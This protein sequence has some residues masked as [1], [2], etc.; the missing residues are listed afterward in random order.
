M[1]R[2]TIVIFVEETSTKRGTYKITIYGRNNQV[3]DPRE[4]NPLLLS[5]DQFLL[6]LLTFD[7]A[8]WAWEE[9]LRGEISSF[10]CSEE[11]CLRRLL[12]LQ[13][14]QSSVVFQI[15]WSACKQKSEKIM[16]VEKGNGII[17]ILW[18][19]HGLVRRPTR[20]TYLS[21]WEAASR[22]VLTTTLPSSLH[23]PASLL[24]RT[25]NLLIFKVTTS[26]TLVSEITSTKML[27]HL[28]KWSEVN[29]N[30]NNNK[31]VRS[32][33]VS[34]K[35]GNRRRSAG[36]QIPQETRW[37]WIYCW[38]D[39]DDDDDGLPAYSHHDKIPPWWE[40]VSNDKGGN[41]S[42]SNSHYSW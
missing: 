19:L 21:M 40:Y 28:T 26:V 11:G 29:N 27:G 3:K 34:S 12:T 37:W 16:R 33:P 8:E 1:K 42:E 7:R 15:C 20:K 35:P 4:R 41:V 31:M 18:I 22:M 10:L 6:T 38:R 5:T 2:N 30:N 32:E 24:R 9:L 23:L 17:G 14:G 13:G 36:E 39:G 25:M